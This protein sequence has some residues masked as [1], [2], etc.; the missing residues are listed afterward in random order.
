[1]SSGLQP[2]LMEFLDQP[3]V[4]AIQAYRDLGLPGERRGLLLTQSDRGARAA[5]DVARMAALCDKEGALETAEASDA[6]ES[7]LLL[8]A[9][10]LVNA[11]METPRRDA[12]RRRR[13]ARGAGCPSC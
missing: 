9:R 6:D 5:D 8:E 12:G 1:M 13:R 10:R 3:A 2:S 7:R 4:R 11:A